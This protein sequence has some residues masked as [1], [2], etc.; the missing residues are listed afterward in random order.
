[1]TSWAD[2]DGRAHFREDIYA[3]ESVL[4]QYFPVL[5]E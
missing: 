1:M 3:R 4:A 2:T 5:A